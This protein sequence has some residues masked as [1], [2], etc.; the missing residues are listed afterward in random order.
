MDA[1]T[2]LPEHLRRAL[3]RSDI[4]SF[5]HLLDDH[6]PGTP[7]STTRKNYTSS[8]RRHLRWTQREQRSILNATRHDTNAYLEL[9]TR[10]HEHAPATIRNHITRLRTLY[11]VLHQIGAHP[12]PNPVGQ[13]PLP[14]HHPEDYRHVYTNA[15]L[16][17]L[18][19]HANPAGRALLLLGAHAGLTGPQVVT[20]R[21]PHVDWTQRRLHL[22][23]HDV[24]LEDDLARALHAHAVEQGHGDLFPTDTLI[25]NLRNDHE[26]RAFIYRLCD[27]ANVTYKAWRALRAHAGLRLLQ[28]SNDPAFVAQHLGVHTLKAIAPLIKLAER[29]ATSPREPSAS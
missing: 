28:A 21:W 16:D 14:P 1:T 3:T 12:G 11:D 7:G 20:L 23:K 4:E 29:N 6:T 25:F 8:W 9:L 13:R 17:L 18:L 24:P 26:L 2:H 27:R 22:D 15:E 10:E 19:T 5:L